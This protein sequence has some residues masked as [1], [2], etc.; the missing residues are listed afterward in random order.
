MAIPFYA[1]NG[2]ESVCSGGSSENA[3]PVETVSSTS[4][5]PI[6]MPQ[7]NNNLHS[8]QVRQINNEA[9]VQAFFEALCRSSQEQN[10]TASSLPVNHS[11]V[12]H[13]CFPTPSTSALS[14]PHNSVRIKRILRR[15]VFFGERSDYGEGRMDFQ[16]EECTNN[17]L[18]VNNQDKPKNKI[19]N[20]VINALQFV[21]DKFK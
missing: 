7:N 14:T 21:I 8:P 18:N 15:R 4:T 5:G 10:L 2:E 13:F 17:Q 20:F 12:D 3:Q 9:I 16:W 1:P 6:E 19:T 11:I